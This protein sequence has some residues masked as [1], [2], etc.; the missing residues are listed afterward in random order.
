MPAAIDTSVRA[1]IVFH[2]ALGYSQQEIADEV[3]VSRNTVRKYLEAARR[4]VEASSNPRD[5]LCAIVEDEYDW[6]GGDRGPSGVD[7]MSM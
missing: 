1:D 6:E 4:N 2:A 5:A 7:L 3:D